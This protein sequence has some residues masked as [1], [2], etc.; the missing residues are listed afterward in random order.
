MK[1]WSIEYTLI[2]NPN[3]V[4]EWPKILAYDFGDASFHFFKI[5]VHK[6]GFA[7]TDYQIVDIKE[8]E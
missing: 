3:K 5:M 8:L 2:D 6:L 4:Y 1:Q 7:K